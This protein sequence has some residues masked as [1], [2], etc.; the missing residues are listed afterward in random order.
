MATKQQLK[1]Q[2]DSLQSE[3]Q[4]LEELVDELRTK[5]EWVELAEKERAYDNA[6]KQLEALREENSMLRQH[7]ANDQS[8]NKEA[9]IATLSRQL[10]EAIQEAESAKERAEA[11]ELEAERMA[12]VVET[13]KERAEAAESEVERMAATV[14]T[15]E[16]GEKAAVLEVTR[17]SEEFAHAELERLRDMNARQTKAE[18]RE[19]QLEAQLGAA[20]SRLQ[21]VLHRTSEAA[22]QSQENGQ[23]KR[24]PT[25]PKPE[26]LQGLQVEMELKDEELHLGKLPSRRAEGRTPPLLR[27]SPL[28]CDSK[29]LPP[30]LIHLQM[31]D[32]GV[33]QMNAGDYHMPGRGVVQFR[34]MTAGDHQMP[35][36][37]VAQTTAGDYQMP[38]RGVVQF[39]QMTAGDHQMP[40]RGVAQT[41]AGD[42]QMPGRGV[43]QFRQMTAGDHQMPDREV[44]QMTAGDHQMP[45]RGVVQFRQMTA[46]DHQMPDRG[47]AQTTAGDYQMPGRGVVQFR[48]MTAGDHQM[49]DRGVAQT[50]AGDYRMPGRG[51]GQF[52]QMTAG[53]H[54]MPDRGVAQTTAGDYQM[55]GRGVVQFRQMTAGDHQ[56]PDRGVAQTTAGDYQMP[57]RGVGQFRQMTAG[58]HQMP[59]RGVQFQQMTA[60]DHQMPDRGVQFR[61]MTAA[62]HQMPDRGVAQTTAGDYQMPGRGVGQFRQ[63][64]AGD[65][66]MPDRGVQFQ[67]MTAG[68]H[69]MPDRGVQFR[70]MTAGDHQM[71]DRG[72]QFRQ[73]TAGDH[74]MPDRGLEQNQQFTQ[75]LG[76]LAQQLPPLPMFS[77]DD[78]ARDSGSFREWLEQFEMVADLTQWSDGVKLKQMVLRLRGS[79]QAFYRTC[80]V[81]RKRDYQAL[82]QDLENRFT[83]VRIQALESSIFRERRQKEGELVDTYAQDLQRLFQKAYPKALQGSED[84]QVMGR[85]VLSNQFIGGLLPDLKRKIAYIEGATFSELWQKAR[86]EE[87]RLQ[88]L[89]RTGPPTSTPSMKQRLH[90]EKQ[91]R[92]GGQP[93]PICPTGQPSMRPIGQADDEKRRNLQFVKCYNCSRYGHLAKDCRSVRQMGEAQARTQN[94]G[95]AKPSSRNTATRTAAVVSVEGEPQSPV[96][97]EPFK[98]MYEMYGVS[99]VNDLTKDGAPR[100]GPTLIIPLKVDGVPVQALIDT[101]CPATIISRE[102]CKRILDNQEGQPLSSEQRKDRAIKRLQQPSLLLKAYCGKELC[103]GAEI[104]V[105]VATPHH[106][107]N[108]VVLVQ[109]DTPVDMLLG[110]DLMFALGIRVLDGDGQSLLE[111]VEE[112]PI[113]GDGQPQPLPVDNWTIPSDGQCDGGSFQTVIQPV[114]I[115]PVPNQVEEQQTVQPEDSQT[116]ENEDSQTVEYEDLQNV[117]SEDSLHQDIPMS[118]AGVSQPQPG[119]T[120]NNQKSIS[121]CLKI[122]NRRYPVLGSSDHGQ[123]RA[124]STTNQ[125]SQSERRI[126]VRLIRACK[127]PG[128]CGKL[129]KAKLERTP[130]VSSLDWLFEPKTGLHDNALEVADAVVKPEEKCIVLPVC[131]SSGSPTRLKRGQVLG[132]LQPA[133]VLDPEDNI[134]A[135]VDGSDATAF[136]E[137]TDEVLNKPPLETDNGSDCET[138]DR[139][140]AEIESNARVG[141]EPASSDSTRVERLKA[142]LRLDQ[143]DVGPAEREALEAFLVDHADLF[144][145]DNSELGCTDVVTHC[146]DTGTHIPV[147]QPPRRTPFALR[148]QVDEM[149]QDML[150]QDIVQPTSSPWAS[151]IV[152]VKK[153]DGSMRFCVDYRRLNSITKLDVY[154]L[155]RIDETLDVLAGARFFTTLD[156]ASGY[157]Q[158]TVD[159]AAREKTAFV[160]HTGLYEFKVMPFGLCNAPATFQRL[161]EVVLAGLNRKQ[162]FVYLDDILI[163]SHNWEE[164]LENLQLVFDR[165]RRAGLRLKPKKCTFAQ[166]KALYLGHIISEEGIEVDPEKV[167]KVRNY[168]IPNNLRSL[169]Q[170]LGLVSYYRRFIPNCS[171]VTNPLHCLTR[172]DVPFIWSDSCQESFDRLKMLLTSTPVLAFPNFQQPFI[173]ETDASGIGLGAVLSQQQEDGS[174]RPS[175]YASRGLQKHERNYSIS[176]LEAL[177]VVW[178]SKHFHVY[179]YGHHCTVYTDHSALKSLLNTPHPSGKLARWGLALQELDLDIQY[180]SGKENKNADVLSR[181]P[182]LLDQPTTESNSSTADCS[183]AR[184]EVEPALEEPE[185]PTQEWQNA[186]KADGEFGSTIAFLGEGTLP[187]DSKSAKKVVQTAQQYSL[188]DGVLYYAQADGCLMVAVPASLRHK[189]FEEAHGGLFSG[190]LREA[191]IYSQ[192]RKHYWWPGMRSDI[193]KWCRACLVCATRK[194][195]QATKPPLCPIPVAGPFDCVGV[196]VLQLPHTLDGNQYA[197]VFVDY[198]TKWPEVFAVPDQTAETIANLFVKEI[199]SRHGVPAKLLS[200]RGTNFLSELMQEIC[201]LM[202]TEKVNTSSYHPQTDGLVERFNRTLTAMLAKTVEKDGRD[203]DHR[204]PYVLFAYRTSLQESTRES[205]FHLLYGRDARLPTEAALSHPRTCYQVDLDDYKVD[206]VANLS[207]AWELARKNVQRAQKQQKRQYDH[208]TTKPTYH[209]GD[210]VFVYQPGSIQSKNRKFARPFHG[211][212]RILDL[213]PTNASVRP[214]DRPEEVPIFISLDRVRKC[215]PEIPDQSWLGPTKKKRKAKRKRQRQAEAEKFIQSATSTGEGAWSG[216]L[217]P[218]TSEMRPREM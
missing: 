214:V 30:P 86:F 13:A 140:E 176:E 121:P 202:G 60:G 156:L 15:A 17:L 72:V 54:Q 217:R 31:P 145:L 55:P 53:D 14:A 183:V 149:V 191:K 123:V 19:Q 153:K 38:G 44:A 63:M 52:R 113:L 146:I 69:Q 78:P 76:N 3:N 174:I 136:G 150:D 127:L 155:P 6:A 133:E 74:Q 1:S 200:D 64:T 24:Q 181:L 108:R 56:M 45:D 144:A 210:R 118:T 206:L 209:I 41:T 77:G 197:V 172:K 107:V 179:L 158:V 154:P 58:D 36:R 73:M 147:R 35:G 97:N 27:E 171:K 207:D 84:A 161:M 104:A 68:D 190:H 111:Q 117:E 102:I 26:L 180:R 99:Q 62:D 7:L 122:G 193:R 82:V 182:I 92:Q 157:W 160:T 187:A 48:Q 130:P 11:A 46:G 85:S 95:S 204:L 109:K 12:A 151:P 89:T 115:Q 216:R 128:R 5:P 66:Q 39:R 141:T 106:A 173:L 81:E 50:T 198:L 129:L 75:A 4:R 21:E 103:I 192:L 194:I 119:D 8:T 203:W 114:E 132:W 100:L 16:E 142:M 94:Q 120:P 166:R 148:S 125:K 218:R 23:H 137:E 59:D 91:Q 42:Y 61:Q 98:W 87:A 168:P 170:F 205:P 80:A 28:H 29:E 22:S 2:L 189:L 40:D 33:V 112:Q 47:V 163:I 88:D 175:A 49:P 211:P 67:Q 134:D 201:K 70:Q 139:A 101:G 186:Q 34:Q 83:P 165:L 20:E 185:V 138:C 162:C 90:Q 143:S 126:P 9:E 135:M 178:A 57:G 177:A 208:H 164:H 159:P 110:T 25:E 124:S 51:V 212:Y 131:N 195:G 199:I 18:K 213:T 215:P 184:V 79:A 169:Q 105:Q 71:P 93:P 196:D 32:R 37:G 43:G 96:E 188:L 167:E 116:V 152:L 10:Q 65:H